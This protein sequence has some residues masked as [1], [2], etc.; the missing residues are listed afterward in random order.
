[1]NLIT[2]RTR[3]LIVED[4]PAY[5]NLLNLAFQLS[6]LGLEIEIVKDGK[7]ARDYLS[8]TQNTP[9]D[10]EGSLRI[11]DLI[12]TDINMP[13]L[14]GLELLAWIRQ[15]AYFKD[16]PV[17]VMSSYIEPLQLE[18]LDSLGANHYFTKP[19]TMTELL[20]NLKPTL[21]QLQ[22]SEVHFSE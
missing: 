1:M 21:E 8:L 20:N 14:S 10:R 12:L 6:D 13:H 4:N 5:A 16:L 11:P 15:N 9:G 19:L 17:I 18:I 22:V 7:E 2:E 3:I